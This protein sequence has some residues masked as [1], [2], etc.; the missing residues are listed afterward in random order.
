MC[1]EIP[2]KHPVASG[3][4]FLKGKS[5]ITMARLCGKERNFSREHFRA[6]GYAVSTVGFELEQVRKYIREQESAD[7]TGGMFKT[8][9]QGAQRATPK[10]ANRPPLRRPHS[11][12]HP[13]CGGGLTQARNETA[14]GADPFCSF[15]ASRH[16]RRNG[17]CANGVVL[18]RLIL[19]PPVLRVAAA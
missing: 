1:I 14:F 16:M 10:G 8:S 4:G 9:D 19:M 7:G 15:I 13:L 6:R 2:A 18:L 17:I 11:S 3:I 5:A 12:S